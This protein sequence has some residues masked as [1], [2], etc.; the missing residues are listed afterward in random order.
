MS[1]SQSST[2]PTPRPKIRRV[3]AWLSAAALLLNWCCIAFG[4]R[5]D[6]PAALLAA[7]IIGLSSCERLGGISAGL[8][9]LSLVVLLIR[10]SGGALC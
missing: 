9:A 4:L 1:D 10:G 2:Q 3:L 6:Y 8:A 7:F 5:T